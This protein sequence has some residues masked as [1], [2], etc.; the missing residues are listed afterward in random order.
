M[1]NTTLFAIML[2]GILCCGYVWGYR[3]GRDHV[4]E[5]VAKLASFHIDI[6]MDNSKNQ[7]ASYEDVRKY[8]WTIAE[9]KFRNLGAGEMKAYRNILQEV[10]QP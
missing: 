1:K 4:K 10:T 6:H 2:F 5:R 3:H 7:I 9:A 8:G